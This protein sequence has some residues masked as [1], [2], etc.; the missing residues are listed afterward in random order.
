MLGI[1]SPDI[2]YHLTETENPSAVQEF[3]QTSHAMYITSTVLQRMPGGEGSDSAEH[4]TGLQYQHVQMLPGSSQC[5]QEG[6][7]YDH[8]LSEHGQSNG[9]KYWRYIQEITTYYLY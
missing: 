8:G 6:V 5:A 4:R 2:K 7:T 9:R 3:L 1:S